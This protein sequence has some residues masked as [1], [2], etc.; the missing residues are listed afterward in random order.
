[1]TD[2]ITTRQS[3]PDMISQ[4]VVTMSPVELAQYFIIGI[5]V[6]AQLIIF[7][8][9]LRNNSNDDSI[10]LIQLGI[11]G[12]FL[13]IFM[14]LLVFVPS[15]IKSSIPEFLGG[16][17]IAASA[18]FLLLVQGPVHWLRSSPILWT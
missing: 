11:F 12:T 5:I 14:G 10:T 17:R 15:D 9:G 4:I 3:I 8:R 1:M 2:P 13:G 18:C 7:R 16:M 6:A